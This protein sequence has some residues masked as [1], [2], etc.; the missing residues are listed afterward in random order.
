M[1][2]ARIGVAASAALCAE[3]VAFEPDRPAVPQLAGRYATIITVQYHNDVEVRSD[4]I[5]AIVTLP[6]AGA[7]GAFEGSYAT[8]DG[9]SGTVGGTLQ[10]DGTMLVTEFAQPPLV[11]LQGATFL[12]RLYPWCDFVRR[13]GTGTLTGRLSGDSLVI[14]GRAS[15]VCTYQDW[16]Q[17]IGIGTDLDV[18]IAGSR[19]VTLPR[20]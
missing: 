4:T 7:H 20:P 8:A 18:R 10:P 6:D 9:G 3:C 1:K 5:A 2:G 15:L 16:E 14:E 17:A 19:A 11:T 13:V 12:H